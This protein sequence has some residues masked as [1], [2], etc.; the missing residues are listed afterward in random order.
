MAERTTAEVV[1]TLNEAQVPCAPIMT[2][3]DVGANSHY[4][5]RGVHIEWDDPQCGPVKGIGVVPKFSR[6]P[7][8]VWRGAPGI[9]HDNR[10][11]YGDLLG[12][13]G[14]DLESLAR[15]KVI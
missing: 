15:E 3:Q 2:A 10:R 5:A 6:T 7:G 9:G 8:K 14:G 12:L 1:R 4:K 13:S 11:V